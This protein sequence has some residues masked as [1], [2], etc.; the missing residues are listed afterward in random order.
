[1]SPLI[2]HH[3]SSMCIYYSTLAKFKYQWLSHSNFT[4][5]Y[6]RKIPPIKLWPVSFWKNHLIPSILAHTELLV[7]LYS[8]NYDRL[9]HT[10]LLASPHCGHISEIPETISFQWQKY[11]GRWLP[12]V[13]GW[14]HCSLVCGKVRYIIIGTCG[15][16][17]CITQG[18]WGAKRNRRQGMSI[19]PP[20][21]G[22]LS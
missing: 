7:I 6:V 10:V 5:H 16:R 2:S 19:S 12:S 8:G 15:R 11:F 18:S 13:V 21:P 9:I 3:V 1:M 22:F 17:R 4:N 14:L 20:G